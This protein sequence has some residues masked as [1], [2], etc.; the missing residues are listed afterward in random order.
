MRF[1]IRSVE[2]MDRLWGLPFRLRR[3]QLMIVNSM[4]PAAILDRVAGLDLP[5][6]GVVHN[7]SLFLEDAAYR[8]FF[9]APQRR[10]VV[11]GEHIARN[12]APSPGPVP[13]IS[14]VVFG[15]A[16]RDLDPLRPT[17]FVVSGNVEF[18]R[19]NYD[20]LLE[21]A[22]ALSA[23]EQPFRIR[24]VG[25]SWTPDGKT[26]HREVDARGLADRFE[27]S[28]GEIDHPQFFD[29]VAGSDFSLPLIDATYERFRSYLETKLA[30]SVPFAIGLGVP[31]VS[32][33][34]L[35]R[36]YRVEGTGPAYEDGGLP[37][38]MRRAIAS[39]AAERAAW[40]TAIAAK[41]EAILGAS[42]ANLRDAIATVRGDAAT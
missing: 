29:L 31:L 30:S 33:E 25:R 20:A 4:E 12:L 22:S 36:A 24:I 11:L 5:L 38:A 9:A 8:A 39:D 10:L 42:L 41:R 3:Y 6:L 14:H 40:R 34:E 23:E 35:V 21:A 13:W 18:Q 26:F 28:R 19:R 16:R 2:W 32:H 37:D 27:F 15:P 7:P 17:T 1:R